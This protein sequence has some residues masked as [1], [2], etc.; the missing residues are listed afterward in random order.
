[1]NIVVIA[2]ACRTS[3]ALTIYRQF[4][5]HLDYLKEDDNWSVFIDESMDHPDLGSKVKYYYITDHSWLRRIRY[6]SGEFEK[7]LESRD[8]HPDVYVSLQNT[9]L[10][11]N[12]RQVI[13]YHQPLPL[14]NPRL[15][16]FN[17]EERRMFLYSKFYGWF[18]A[19]T[20]NSTTDVVVQIPYI[21]EGVIK[22]YGIPTDRV[23]VLFP[24]VEKINPDDIEAHKF[25]Q[26]TIN[27]LFPAGPM[28]YKNHKLLIRAV[29]FLKQSNPSLVANVKVLFTFADDG[30]LELKKLS[31]EL[32]V[33]SNFVFYPEL[34]HDKL[35]SYYKGADG[36]LFPSTIETLGLPLLE[37][38]SFGL[39][40]VVADLPYSHQVLHNYEG[41][42][43]TKVESVETWASAI[44][45]ISTIK[46]RYGRLV[47]D[48]ES[49]WGAFFS[50][51]KNNKS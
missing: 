23:H 28:I 15:N 38:A 20:I 37:A 6:D 5:K 25:E 45:R 16:I 36:V 11:T 17:A 18:V 48:E 31:K 1:M 51:V 47:T 33:E 19:R 3:G 27:L 4:I 44:E 22:K 14:Y 13:Y 30:K 40:I 26:D 29:S 10:V 42:F 12:K 24:D 41:A 43:Y 35:L 46:K 21:A 50:I 49:S 9:G 7:M 39:P 34:S 2:Y 32:K 8:I